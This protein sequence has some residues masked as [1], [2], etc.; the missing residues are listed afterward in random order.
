[1]CRHVL[2]TSVGGHLQYSF[3]KDESQFNHTFFVSTQTVG[4]EIKNLNPTLGRLIDL[5]PKGE[6]EYKK[7]EFMDIGYYDI[8]GYPFES[9]K[10]SSELKG[11]SADYSAKSVGDLSFKTAW[12]E[13]ARGYGIGESLTLTVNKDHPPVKSIV[14]VNGFVRSQ[15]HWTEHSRVK[16]LDMFVNGRHYARLNLVDTK[17]EQ[18]FK[19][20]SND[21]TEFKRSL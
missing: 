19:F 10:A 3:V 4:Q 14:I 17:Q 2:Y 5:S 7:D 18:E 11:D 20:D 1:V 15:K 8:I 21:W 12:V 13:G 9:Q 6:T 16:S